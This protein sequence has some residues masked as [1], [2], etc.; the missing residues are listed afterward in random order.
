MTRQYIKTTDKHLQLHSVPLCTPLHL[1]KF[2]CPISSSLISQF[3]TNNTS[4]SHQSHYQWIDLHF[5]AVNVKGI[6]GNFSL[7]AAKLVWLQSDHRVISI[8]AVN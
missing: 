1:Q 4:S 2:P 7:K 6:S 5:S 3:F 8:Q